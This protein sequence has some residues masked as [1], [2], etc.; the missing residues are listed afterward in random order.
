MGYRIL[1]V[2]RNVSN[3]KKRGTNL[4]NLMK[5][6]E[7]KSQIQFISRMNIWESQVGMLKS[8]IFRRWN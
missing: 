4:G 1:Y 3:V 2:S 5:A 8:Q 6:I 7:L